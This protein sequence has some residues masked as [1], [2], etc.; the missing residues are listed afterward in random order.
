MTPSPEEQRARA[1][2]LR[3]ALREAIRDRD[4]AL[5]A[6]VRRR[7]RAVETAAG[8]GSDRSDAGR[9]PP[10]RDQVRRALVLLG[11]PAAPKLLSTVHRAFFDE[12]I[13]PSRI[14]SLRRDEER[15]F[16]ARGAARAP[17]VCAALTH[18][19]FAPVRGLL[20]LSDWP[21]ERRILGPLGPRVD[22]LTHVRNLALR[23]RDIRAAGGT[24]S[25]A[26][27][28][29]L[30][31]FALTVP[32][33]HRTDDGPDPAPDPDLL[34]RAAEAEARLHA[35]VDDRHR[36]TAAARARAQLPLDRQLFGAAPLQVIRPVTDLS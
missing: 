35:A 2:E 21:L 1:A 30:R 32:G 33:S 12:P 25:P 20:A 15:S 27:A 17:Y 11:A 8:E 3:A 6:R 19:R 5:A 23:V 29:L 14:A 13:V 36:H 34:A 7:L 10:A 22:H 4:R 31:R 9:R 18:D 24:E 26:A 28:D 16:A